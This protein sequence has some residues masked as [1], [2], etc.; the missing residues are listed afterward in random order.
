MRKNRAYIFPIFICF[1][2]FSFK[3]FADVPPFETMSTTGQAESEDDARIGRAFDPSAIASFKVTIKEVGHSVAHNSPSNTVKLLVDASSSGIPDAVVQLG[4]DWVIQSQ[5]ISL[6]KGDEV[7]VLGSK[8]SIGGQ[9]Y[10]IA[11]K[12]KKGDEVMDLRSELGVP[13]WQDK[14]WVP[15]KE[16]VNNTP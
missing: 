16:K 5:G 7:T 1:L 14:N 13:I 11:A 15:P 10:I 6:K 9:T 3:L 2:L 8:A 12:L 4:P